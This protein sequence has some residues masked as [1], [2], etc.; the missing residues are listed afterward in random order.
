MNHSVLR[1]A[2]YIVKATAKDWKQPVTE[3]GTEE[4]ER[5][6]QKQPRL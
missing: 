5:H 2:L 4:E 3:V 1:R 6:S